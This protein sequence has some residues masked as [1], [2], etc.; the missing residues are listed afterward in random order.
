MRALKLLIVI[1]IAITIVL[2]ISGLLLTR[3]G[4]VDAVGWEPP[5]PPEDTGVLAE[6]TDLRQA[7]LLALGAVS[8][9]EDIAIDN[10]GN[11]YSGTADD[12]IVRITPD[13]QLETLVNTGGRPLGMDCPG[14]H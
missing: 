5:T 10:D 7:T 9:P 11:L 2:L 13:A 1:A 4:A 8:G 3:P 6:N 12:R 14:Q